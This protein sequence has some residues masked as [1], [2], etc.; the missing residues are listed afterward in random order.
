[1]GG[2]FSC[3]TWGDPEDPIERIVKH[4]KREVTEGYLVV[5]ESGTLMVHRGL[6]VICGCPKDQG[7]PLQ[8]ELDF[9]PAVVL[10]PVLVKEEEQPKTRV[11]KQVFKPAWA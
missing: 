1:M 9:D 11:A 5:E 6:C 10:E 4:T 8:M 3:Y 7:Q 2:D